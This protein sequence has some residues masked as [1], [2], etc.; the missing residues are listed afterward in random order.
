MIVVKD[1]RNEHGLYC[2][3]GKV[4]KS[5]S[6]H[7]ALTISKGP[8]DINLWHRRFINANEDVIKHRQKSATGTD[9]LTREM[10]QCHLRALGTASKQQF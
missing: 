5:E 7:A 3:E 8:A 6:N 10:I 9:N 4:S 1:S 2:F